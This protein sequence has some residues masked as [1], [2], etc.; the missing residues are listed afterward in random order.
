MMGAAQ[1]FDVVI[2]GGGTAGCM[3]AARLAA[4]GSRSVL[5]L[6]AGPDLRARL[7]DGLRD[8]WRLSGDFDW[9]Y[10]SEPDARGVVEDLRGASCGG[11]LLGDQVR[12]PR[13]SRRL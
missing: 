8:G 13:V 4:A 12:L 7:P 2:A 5:L 1:G 9:G 6:E 10:R 11:H 3:V